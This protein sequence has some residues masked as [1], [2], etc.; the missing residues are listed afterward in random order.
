[1]KDRPPNGSLV[2]IAAG[3]ATV[4]DGDVTRSRARGIT[5]LRLHSGNYYLDRDGSPRE[6][7]SRYSEHIP[8]GMYELTEPASL[9]GFCAHC[10]TRPCRRAS[11]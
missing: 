4:I 11:A 2:R 5:V 7:P 3:L 9:T 8:D 1:V 6:S 10:G